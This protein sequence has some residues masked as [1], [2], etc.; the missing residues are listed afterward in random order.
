MHGHVRPV[1]KWR[2]NPENLRHEFFERVRDFKPFQEL[3]D[4][5]P[6]VVFFVK[7]RQS[8]F[9]MNNLRGVEVCGAESEAQTLG[10]Q[11]Y[12][13]FS[14]DLMKLYLQQDRQVMETGE[15]IIN[16]ICPAPQKGSNALIIYSKVPLRDRRGR[17]IGLAGIYR[18]IRGL[19]APEPKLRRIA[20][21]VQI[22]QERYAEPL[23]VAELA[24]ETGLSRSQFDRQFQRLF[25]MSPREY[26]LRV[27]VRAACRMLIQ[28]EDQVTQIALQTGFYDHSHFSR[29]FRRIMGT[30]PLVF[31]RRHAFD[32]EPAKENS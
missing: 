26:L 27:R 5:L 20:C 10:K 2:M 31:R 19:H 22:I 14:D 8:R 11:G 1:Y 6:D 28:T 12:E 30:S 32:V 3:L 29:T 4:Q 7:D 24:A 23:T 9:M 16:A 18:E 15:P 13:F 17:I 21:A 25:G